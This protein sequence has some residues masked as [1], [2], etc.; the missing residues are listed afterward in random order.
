MFFN[1]PVFKTAFLT[2]L[3]LLLNACANLGDL[4]S[5]TQVIQPKVKIADA[6]VS[7]FSSDTVDLMI[8]L[9]V[10]NPNP[11]SIK[12]AGYDYEIFINDL[13]F[14][15]GKQEMDT[16]IAA[17]TTSR[18]SFPVSIKFKELFDMV[19]DLKTSKE[20]QY[21]VRSTAYLDL[22]VIGPLPIRS[23]SKGS[24]PV[25]HTPKLSVKNIN[26]KSLSFT[27]ADL[28]VELNIFNPNN[29]GID[30]TQLNY[31]FFVAKQN[32]A[33]SNL[34]QS[35]NL[36][37]DS[38]N[39]VSIPV[40]LSLLD[41]GASIFEVLNGGKEIPYQVKGDLKLDT[42]L[43]LVKGVKLPIDYSGSTK[44]IRQ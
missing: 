2:I 26:L 27:G 43:P 5:V 21:E 28:E 39:S 30:I 37:P 18:T 12:L 6:T 36:K 20:M 31:Q 8:G 1:F 19:K 24:L 10:E 14:S 3:L 15:K 34:T 33:S 13:Q 22:P 17:S 41:M 40:S 29:F 9:D 35:L 25:P 23:S 44:I 32:W 7:N 16:L 42:T 4:K 11:L 38:D